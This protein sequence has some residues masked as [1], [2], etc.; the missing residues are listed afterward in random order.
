MLLSGMTD[1]FKAPLP[2]LWER[3]PRTKRG[4]LFRKDLHRRERVAFVPVR[5]VYMLRL[6][7][8]CGFLP[9]RA[10]VE[11]R[12]SAHQSDTAEGED[13]RADAAGDGEGCAFGVEDDDGF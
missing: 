4:S 9:A 2:A 8:F 3:L 11:Q 12:R 10:D 1:G 5:Y 7:D 13:Q 6:L